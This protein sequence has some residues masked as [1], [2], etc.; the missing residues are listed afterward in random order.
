[1]GE[2]ICKLVE[3]KI[4]ADCSLVLPIVLP[5]NAMPPN[6]TEKTFANSHKTSK[7]AK[8]FSLESFPLYG[9]EPR[10]RLEGWRVEGVSGYEAKLMYTLR[11]QKLYVWY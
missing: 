8:V 10:S 1:M 3:N 9:S 6:F 7:F 2:N 5:K 4:F 11:R